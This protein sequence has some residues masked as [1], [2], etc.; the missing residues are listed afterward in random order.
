MLHHL[1][2]RV[3]FGWGVRIAGFVSGAGC[4]VATI[5]TTNVPPTESGS[6]LNNEGSDGY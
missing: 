2:Q 4:V 3:G 6:M 1:F 5:L